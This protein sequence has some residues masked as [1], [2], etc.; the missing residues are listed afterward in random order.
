MTVRARTRI[1]ARASAPPEAAA[2][3][4]LV[5][6]SLHLGKHVV[7]LH[8]GAV[9]YFR[10]S[11]NSWRAALEAVKSLG[12]TIVETY[13]PWGVHELADGSFDFGEHDP[14]KNLARFLETAHSLGLYAFV[15]PGPNINAELTYFGLPRRIVFDPECQARSPRGQPLP[16][17]A[18]PKMFPVPSY[19]SERFLAETERWFQK[20]AEVVRPRVWPAGPVVLMQVDN[21]ASFYFRDAPYD[22]DHHPDAQTK[23]ATQLRQRY[24]QIESLNQAYASAHANW[25]EVT[26]PST[27]PADL[28][29]ARRSLDFMEF[30]EE[31]IAS[32]LERMRD[33]LLRS[34]GELPTVH[35]V[36]MGEAGLPTSLARLDQ[37]VD[38]NGLDYYHLRT[39]LDHVRDRTLHMV[40]SVRC[41]FSPEMGMG[42]PPWFA[43]RTEGD[44][45]QTTL[46]AFA[47][48]L[49][50][51]NLYMAVDRDRWYGA[52]FDEH[53]RDRELAPSLRRMF[54]GLQ[55][56][57]FHTLR[58]RVAIGIMIP[59][60]YRDLARSMHT[61]G[62]FS[63][64]L[65]SLAGSGATAACH[66][67]P[68]GFAQ[69]IQTEYSS[70]IARV[71]EA[72]ARA[73]LPYVFVESDADE[74]CLAEL[75]VLITPSYEFA[76]RV[77]WQRLRAFAANGG[78]VI[79]GPRLPSLDERFNAFE[80]TAPDKARLCTGDAEGADALARDLIKLLE[81]EPRFS[82]SQGVETTVHEDDSG[83]R[84]MFA[85]QRAARFVQCEIQLPE[86]MAL[87]DA[88]TDERFE[89]Q[90]S[91][92]VP[93]SGN[94]C[95]ML[96]CER[97][98][99]TASR[100][101]PPSARRSEPPC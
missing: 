50:G 35:N 25:G 32:A 54:A 23:Y 81:F 6:C 63:P 73:E 85:I 71:A 94:S 86:P 84:V 31:L 1:S 59:K 98:N 15:R 48:G 57:E 87:V 41:P 70:F 2:T 88:I 37:I 60:E 56:C 75:K 4:S 68:L 93:M 39:H 83:P 46:C 91:V 77:R 52:P 3:P 24:G 74:A 36:P 64:S 67:S 51:L 21:E 9:H 99:N 90:Q 80:F 5:G 47:Y 12:C 100:R 38:A 7:P 53:G 58:R 19:A 14:S 78:Q 18:P 92:R 43:L 13:V 72:L 95:R 10:L 17:I 62:A 69:P 16:F 79:Y 42:A 89:G 26:P 96:L 55:R 27:V 29:S 34:F 49:R 40:G 101:K 33:A 11:P 30:H 8:A 66:Q 97:T 20:V 22:Q 28:E 45:L 44:S 65:L 82:A 61:L 76:Q